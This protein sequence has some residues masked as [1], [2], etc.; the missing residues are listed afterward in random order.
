MTHLSEELR[1]LRQFKDMTLQE[2]ADK[3]KISKQYLSMLEQ[4]KRTRISF[5]TAIQISICYEISLE[6]LSKFIDL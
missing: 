3:M 1:R 4:G 5:E 2:A 6:H